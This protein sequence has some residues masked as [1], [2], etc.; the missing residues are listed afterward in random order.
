MTRIRF[1]GC[2]LSP[3]GAPRSGHATKATRP[4]GHNGSMAVE[5]GAWADLLTGEE[6]AYLGSDPAR[7]A[8]VEP[9]PDDLHPRVREALARRGIESL[10]G[11]QAEA[12]DAARGGDNVIVT[13]GTASGKTL[14][15]N[16]P[17]LDALAA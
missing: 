3:R 12:W 2:V 7:E 17:V 4:G 10:Y 6:L 14:A 16:L 9:I 11:H 13:T 8:R 1:D 5:T 15:F